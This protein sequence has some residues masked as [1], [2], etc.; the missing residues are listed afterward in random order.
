MYPLAIALAKDM[1][2]PS[3]G[4][5][6]I[7]TTYGDHLYSKGDF[8]NAVIEYVRTIGRLE[9][10]YVIK[11]FLDAQRIHNL[12]AYLEALHAAPGQAN[13]DHTTLLLNCYTKLK[14]LK[15]KDLKKLD[16]FIRTKK[17]LHFDVDT[18]I[19]VLRQAGYHEHALFL[20]AKYHHHDWHLKIML[21]DAKDFKEALRYIAMLDFFEAEM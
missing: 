10:S 3:D 19:Q 17:D 18:A 1:K 13:E 5:I 9:P 11:R 14:D 4:I 2:Y 16:E 6:D 15:K 21:E 7:Y 8:D 20:A 12:T